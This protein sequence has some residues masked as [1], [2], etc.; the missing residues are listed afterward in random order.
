[1]LFVLPISCN[2]LFFIILFFNGTLLTQAGQLAADG[3]PWDTGYVD[4]RDAVKRF[5]E[6]GKPPRAYVVSLLWKTCLKPCL[7][8]VALQLEA[9]S[10]LDL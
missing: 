2:L 3:I 5:L 4:F 1:M 9:D 8:R 10:Y 6:K 7:K